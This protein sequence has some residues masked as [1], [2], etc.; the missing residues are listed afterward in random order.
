MPRV[1]RYNSQ[2]QTKKTFPH[3]AARQSSTESSHNRLSPRYRQPTRARLSRRSLLLFLARRYD[4]RKAVRHRFHSVID[5]VADDEVPVERKSF[6][7]RM[8]KKIAR[9]SCIFSPGVDR[10][11]EYSVALKHVRRSKSDRIGSAVIGEYEIERKLAD[12]EFENEVREGCGTFV[13]PVSR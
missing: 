1:E 3:R 9:T 2:K 10:G 6:K 5:P 12:R 4:T 13:K 8:N 11:Y 7:L